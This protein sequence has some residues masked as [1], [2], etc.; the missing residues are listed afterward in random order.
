MISTLLRIYLVE[1]KSGV[2]IIGPWSSALKDN[3][4]KIFKKITQ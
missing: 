4:I 2:R 1:I 3:T